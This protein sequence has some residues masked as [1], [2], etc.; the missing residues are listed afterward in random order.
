MFLPPEPWP[1]PL[2][3]IVLAA[4][5]PGAAD[6]L[7]ERFAVSHKCLVPIGGQPL[8]AHVIATLQR[9]PSIGEIII[10]VEPTA[11]GAIGEALPPSPANGPP[12]RFAAAWDTITDSVGVAAAGHEGPLLIT[13]ADNVLLAQDS[14]DAVLAGL[15][16]NDAVVAMTTREA[17]LAAN[18]E[19]QRRFY[20]FRC[21]A[22]SNCNLYGLAGSEALKAAEAFRSG[23]R[24]AKNAGRIV[25]AF[26]LTNLILL[27]LRIITLQSGLARIS[28]RLGVRIAPVVLADGSQ[29]ID[30]D[31][32]R[33]YAIAE[34]LL[35]RAPPAANVICLAPR[36]AL[37][38]A[39]G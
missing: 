15:K 17:V 10:S 32:D 18:P 3:V 14:I 5:R 25:R 8:I 12:V 24:F 22:Y 31:N 38:I 2:R 7:A 39:L 27:R 28:R 20:E 6:P 34:T 21:G 29:A 36:E 1:L 35:Q 13:T 37:A 19:G 11:F 4:Q 16:G 9:H 33:T 23:G 26:S 30:V